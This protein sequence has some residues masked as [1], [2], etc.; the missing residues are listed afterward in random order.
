[1]YCR[2][3]RVMRDVGFFAVVVVVAAALRGADF[4][5]EAILFGTEDSSFGLTPLEA[6]PGSPSATVAARAQN[7]RILL[8]YQAPN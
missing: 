3:G 5:A 1:M 6:N 4:G 8:F 2:L 7:F